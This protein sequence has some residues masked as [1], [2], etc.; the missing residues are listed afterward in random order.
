MEEETKK[1]KIKKSCLTKFNA[2]MQNHIYSILEEKKRTTTKKFI[3]SQFCLHLIQVLLEFLLLEIFFFV[4]FRL[5]AVSFVC[6][7]LSI[8]MLH[9]THSLPFDFRAPIDSLWL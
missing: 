9:L 8:A 6:I 3:K 5:L 1:K 7:I 4:S 2:E